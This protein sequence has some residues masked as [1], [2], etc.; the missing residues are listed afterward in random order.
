MS[1]NN[2]DCFEDCKVA[3]AGD[4]GAVNQKYVSGYF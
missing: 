1:K 3:E 4:Q 2:E